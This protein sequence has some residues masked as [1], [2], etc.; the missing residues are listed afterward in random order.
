VRVERIS[1]TIATDFRQ[2]I[3][4]RSHR[5]GFRPHRRWRSRHVG[6]CPR[7]DCEIRALIRRMSRENPLWGAPR[8]HRELLMLG[9]KVAESTVSMRTV[10]VRQVA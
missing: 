4:I 6:G 9:I 5:R 7:I 10:M 2:G 1:A 8:I 3:V